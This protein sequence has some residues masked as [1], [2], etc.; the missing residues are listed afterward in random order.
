MMSQEQCLSSG[1]TCE[2]APLVSLAIE[3]IR[4]YLPQ[5]DANRRMEHV[6]DIGRMVREC[7]AS[8]L[9]AQLRGGGELEQVSDVMGRV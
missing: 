6:A 1:Q 4:H 3:A 2:P 9:A 7:D 8:I 5:V